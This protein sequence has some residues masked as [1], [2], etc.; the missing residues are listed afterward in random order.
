MFSLN[1]TKLMPNQI[2]SFFKKPNRNR[3]AVKNIFRT[4]LAIATKMRD[5]VQDRPPSMCKISATSIQVFRRR[6]VPKRQ[7]DRQTHSKFNIPITMGQIIVYATLAHQQIYIFS[8]VQDAS[9]RDCPGRWKC[10]LQNRCTEAASVVYHLT[11]KNPRQRRGDQ[12]CPLP[13]E[14]SALHA[15]SPRLL[16]LYNAVHNVYTYKL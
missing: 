15:H 13:T 1:R 14:A 3:T 16:D 8:A 10:I 9:T 4:S 6:C 12:I 5:S 11:R 7:T 2:Q